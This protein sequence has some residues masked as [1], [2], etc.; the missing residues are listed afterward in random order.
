MIVV[1]VA[2]PRSNGKPQSQG[3]GRIL[4]LIKAHHSST[5]SCVLPLGTKRLLSLTRSP[6]LPAVP[7]SCCSSP[8]LS[9]SWRCRAGTWSARWCASRRSRVPPSGRLPPLQLLHT[10]AVLPQR[11]FL[12]SGAM[13]GWGWGW[14]STWARGWDPPARGASEWYSTPLAFLLWRRA[15][16]SECDSPGAPYP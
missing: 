10:R 15:R 16:P 6:R 2:R 11:P 12:Q 9:T 4:V 13:W 3:L 5:H 1:L 8:G 7:L 14:G